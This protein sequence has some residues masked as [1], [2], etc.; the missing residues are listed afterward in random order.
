MNRIMNR[1]GEEWLLDIAMVISDAIAWGLVAVITVITSVV[2][3]LGLVWLAYV[4]LPLNIF[5]IVLA[6]LV[7]DILLGIALRSI[8]RR[9]S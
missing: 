2:V 3:I 7:V 8:L 1:N 5:R 6:L 4:Y 9:R